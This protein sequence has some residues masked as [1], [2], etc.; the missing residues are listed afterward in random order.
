MN[1]V[2]ILSLTHFYPTKGEDQ[3]H[4]DSPIP[5]H[6]NAPGLLQALRQAVDCVPV[7]EHQHMRAVCYS[8]RFTPAFA[9]STVKSVTDMRRRSG[10]MG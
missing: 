9:R 2:R 3:L 1:I 4:G 6:S 7:S 8:L 5:H 10:F